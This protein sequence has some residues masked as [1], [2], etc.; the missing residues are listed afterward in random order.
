MI[1][2]SIPRK[3][4]K[5]KIIDTA[6]RLFQRQGYHATGLNQITQESGAPKGSLY[7]YFPNGKE[8]L[9]SVA[10][11]RTVDLVAK[12]IQ[13]GLKR[14][15]DPIEAIQQFIFNLATEFEEDFEKKQGLPVASVAL[16]TAHTSE[17]IRQRCQQA[18]EKWHDIFA[19][20]LIEGGVEQEKATELGLVINAMIEG[21]FIIVI[22]KKD[23]EPLRQIARYI[24][25]LLK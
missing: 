5:D 8:E 19:Q 7:Y 4:S 23:S 17:V 10:V 13:D 25:N 2:I 6:S 11:G 14:Y 16:E 15:D 12:R 18:Y 21:A 24:P 20:K 9:A 3:S 22:T 1:V